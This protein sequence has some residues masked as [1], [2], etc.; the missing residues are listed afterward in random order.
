M[1]AVE[2]P[3][4]AEMPEVEQHV[5]V[6]AAP[7]VD[8]RL[9]GARDD[10]ARGEL[11]RVGRVAHEEALAVLV[12]EI[13]PLS[14]AALGDE[15]AGRCERRRVELHHLHVL[16]RDSRL[17]RERHPVA[18]AGVGVRR[19]R[20]QTAGPSRRE[21]RGLRA[22]R[23]QPAVHEI[24]CDDA[25]AALVVDDELP[26]EEL[27]VRRDVPLH[28]LL[29]EHVDEDVAGDV[30]CVRRARL[31]GGA[32]RTLGDPS[33]RRA[34]EDRPPLLELVDV[35]GC[36][37]AEDLDRVL[38]PEVVGA[39]HG[40]ERVLLGIVLRG[41]A[42]RGVDAPLGR[43]RVASHRVDLRQQGDVRTRVERFDRRAHPGAAGSDDH[44]IVN[45]VHYEGR[46]LIV[47]GSPPSNPQRRTNVARAL[48]TAL[49]GTVHVAF[50][51][52]QTP[53]QARSFQP[54]AGVAV[55]RTAVNDGNDAE[56]RG[57][58][59]MPVRELRTEPRPVTATVSRKVAGAKRA[60]TF[61][62]VPT[63]TRQPPLPVHAPVQRTSFA[64]VPGVAVSASR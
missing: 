1:Q 6:E 3:L 56:Q 12:Q 40:V 4:G 60:D 31:A 57:R 37:V 62:P 52:R 15:H 48:D 64:P 16:Q 11:H 28:H 59:V 34:R 49:I 45:R 21:D 50:A 8:L 53:L 32:E 14:A 36:L 42:E 61:A 24:P 22:D 47:P 63:S 13:R 54:R 23:V 29:V 20:V 19:P 5:P 26:G 9:L 30:R 43:A 55:S 17:E 10:V 2:D 35:A 33:V 51:P 58:Q 27:L 39:L 18:G 44:D 46:Y 7:L 25:L 41:V 38:V